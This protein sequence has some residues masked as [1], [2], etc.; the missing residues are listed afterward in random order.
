MVAERQEQI[1]KIVLDRAFEVHSHL[2]AG[3]LEKVYQT[4]LYYELQQ[5]GLYVE[6]E[7]QLPVKYKSINVDCGYRVDLLIEHDQLIIECKSV[8]ILH[9]IHTSQLLNYMRLSGISLGLMFNF[10]VRHLK[11]G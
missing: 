6:A 3:L 7:K 4:C 9:D 5:S 11:E 2:G 1:S 8:Q 10:N